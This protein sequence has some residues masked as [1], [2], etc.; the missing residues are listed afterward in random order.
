MVN[1]LKK[2]NGAVHTSHAPSSSPR[3]E[4]SCA[5]RRNGSIAARDQSQQQRA[6]MRRKTHRFSPPPAETAVIRRATAATK[7]PFSPSAARPAL[8]P[9]P[10]AG[11]A[12]FVSRKRHNGQ[13]QECHAKQK[14]AACGHQISSL[15]KPSAPAYNVP[16]MNPA[17]LDPLQRVQRIAQPVAPAICTA[18]MARRTHVRLMPPAS[19]PN[20]NIKRSSTNV[21]P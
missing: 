6:I 19:V 17:D 4:S 9:K 14:I 1:Q 5:P 7:M 16:A 11:V 15:M 12:F 21:W 13:N 20:Q 2:R 8:T 10:E 18:Q 3:S